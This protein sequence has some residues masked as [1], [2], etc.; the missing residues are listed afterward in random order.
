MPHVRGRGRGDLRIRYV[1]RTPTDLTAEEDEL[2][3]RLAELRGTR[4]THRATAWSAASA[5]PSSRPPGSGERPT[6]HE[7]P[8]VFVDDVDR[9]ELDDGDRH[10]LRKALRLHP[11]DP[12]IVADGAG[13]WRHG[14]LRRRGGA[15]RRGGRR[16]PTRPPR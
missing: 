2:Y 10:H 11:G 9:P 1:V 12:L 4:S 3:R 16:P 7:G 15:R 13:A 8:L 5:K 6:G 14:P